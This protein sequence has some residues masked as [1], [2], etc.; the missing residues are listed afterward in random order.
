M[1]TEREIEL[2]RVKG[3]RNLGRLFQ[4]SGSEAVRRAGRG[5]ASSAESRLAAESRYKPVNLGRGIMLDTRTGKSSIDPNYQIQL[6]A[7]RAEK[8][9][10]QGIKDTAAFKRAEIKQANAYANM[11]AKQQYLPQSPGTAPGISRKPTQ[12]T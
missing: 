2:N 10:M 7:E 12:R 3:D 5:M 9:R 1:P 4:F 6:D 8:E 11:L